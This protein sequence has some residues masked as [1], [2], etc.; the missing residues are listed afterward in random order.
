MVSK[1]QASSGLVLFWETSDRADCGGPPVSMEGA[2][3]SDQ[4]EVS[5]GGKVVG[6]V[7]LDQIRRGLEAGSI[8]RDAQGREVGSSEWV[9]VECLLAPRADV[10]LGSAAP[11]TAA[12]TAEA[13]LRKGVDRYK[14]LLAVSES[15]RTYGGLLKVFGWIVG[16]VAILVALVFYSEG[17]MKLVAAL[18]GLLF[19]VAL[20]VAGTFIAAAGEGLLALAD[21]ATNTT[22]KEGT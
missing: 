2:S 5:V 18:T 17:G 7:S 3:V 20:H 8:P 4:F 1:T 21:I 19:A 11:T 22:P 12:Q 10:P 14:N 9:P 16:G 13:P 6:P 15:L